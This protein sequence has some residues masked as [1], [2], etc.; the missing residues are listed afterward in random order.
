MQIRIALTAAAFLAASA[1]ARAQTY[2]VWAIDQG[3]ATVHVYNER[4]EETAK[5]DLGTHGVRV[6]HM[7]DFTPDGAYALIAAT[8]SGNV[9]VVRAADR[10]VVAVPQA[11]RFELGRSLVIAEDPVFREKAERFKDIGAVCQQYTADGRQAYVTL[12]PAIAN[13][14][15]VVLDTEKFRL[16][17]AYPP[18]ELRVN[19]GTV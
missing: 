15:L 12:G 14:G 4:L 2:E 1:T 10:Q 5:L 16:A 8:A 6:P 19:C 18:D 13:G 7:V 11:G 17:A 3:T 9:T